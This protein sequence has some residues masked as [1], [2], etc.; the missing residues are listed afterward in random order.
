MVDADGRDGGARVPT[1]AFSRLSATNVLFGWTWPQ[2]GV[3]LAGLVMVVGGAAAG[4]VLPLMLAGGVVMAYGLIRYEGL[5]LM[6]WTYVWLAWRRRVRDGSTRWSASPLAS[7]R[8]AGVLGVRGDG[9]QR[10]LAV[11]GRIGV[12]VAGVHEVSFFGQDEE[13]TLTHRATSRQIFVNGALAAAQKLVAREPGFYTFDQV[14]F[15]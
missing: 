4:M 10:V 1:A 7:G 15:A 6:A 5:S 11:R 3:G 2:I 14:M 12:R 13:V 8:P 9:S